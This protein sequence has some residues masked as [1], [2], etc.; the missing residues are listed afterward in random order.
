MILGG[1]PHWL[2]AH[3][4]LVD[5]HVEKSSTYGVDDDRFSNFTAIAA[6][7]GAP[8]ERYVLE[9]IVEKATR[10]LNMIDAG[11]AMAVK[12][13]PDIASLGLCAEAL[14]RRALVEVASAAA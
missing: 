12:E 6:A 3:R 5:L 11:A 1:D 2:A 14:Q 10:A 4:D 13:Y 8:P 7:T 9:R